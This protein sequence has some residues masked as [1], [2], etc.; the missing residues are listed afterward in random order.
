MAEQDEIALDASLRLGATQTPQVVGP[1]LEAE[2]TLGIPRDVAERNPQQVQAIQQRRAQVPSRQIL[3]E[4]PL[5]AEFMMDPSNAALAQKDVP[6]LMD[7]ERRIQSSDINT[8]ANT[9]RLVGNRTNTLTGNLLQAVASVTDVFKHV[10][11]AI[12]YPY[13]EGKEAGMASGEELNRMGALSRGLRQTGVAVAEG[14]AY[15]YIPEFTFDRMLAEPTPSNIAGLLFEQGVGS[16]PDMLAA[17]YALPAYVTSLSQEIAAER[18]A[19]NGGAP[20]DISDIV[21]VL[22]LSVAIAYMDRFSTKGMLGALEESVDPAT[23]RQVATEMA[24]ASGREAGTEFIQESAQ[25][26]GELA[27]TDAS[28]GQGVT[29]TDSTQ[30][31]ELA[32]LF[33]A[34]ARRGAE[35]AFIGAG[36]G[37][38]VRGVT[39]SVQ[40]VAQRRSRDLTTEL[41]SRF[42]QAD[43]DA[44][45]MQLQDNTFRQTSTPR[46]E[47]FVNEISQGQALYLAPEVLE[48]AQAAGIDVPF[49]AG[50]ATESADLQISYADIASVVDNKDVMAVLRPY[51]KRSP[52]QLSQTELKEQQDTTETLVA[53]ATQ[54]QTVRSEADAIYDSVRE[55]IVATGRQGEATARYSAELIPAYVTTKVAELRARGIETSVQDVYDSLGLRIEK[56]VEATPDALKQEIRP[57]RENL[58]DVLDSNFTMGTVVG[59]QMLPIEGLTTSMSAAADD[60][61]RVKTLAEQIGSTEGFIERVIVDTDG[62]VI[63]GQHRVEALRQLGITSVPATVVRDL[64]SVVSAVKGA[65]VRSEHARQIVDHVVEIRRKGE[66]VAEY[67]ISPELAE[68]Y[69]VAE[70]MLPAAPAASTTLRQEAKSAVVQGE[71]L[72][73]DNEAIIRL[74]NASDLSTFL[75]EAG[76]LFLEAERRFAVKY[77][78]SPQ[79]EALLE[80]LGV[81]GFDEIG[82]PQHEMFARTFEDYLR[83]GKAPSLRLR[84]AFAAFSRWL[85]RIYQGLVRLGKELD[86]D[87]VAVFDRLLAT[88]VEMDEAAAS[89][90]YQQYFRSQEQSGMTDAQW[91]KYT[92]DQAKRRDRSQMNL[93]DKLLEQ[94]RRT[95]TEEW[96]EERRHLYDEEMA[97][98]AE[99]PITGVMTALKDVKL[100]AAAVKAILGVEHIPPGRLLSNSRTSDGIDPAVLA[101]GYGYDSVAQMLDEIQNYTRITKDAAAAAADARMLEKYGDILNDGTIE[102]EAREAFHNDAQA[103]VLLAEIAAL[104]KQSRA[105]RKPPA[106]NREELKARAEQSVSTMQAS[107][108]NPDR[109]YRAEVRAAKKAGATKDPAEALQLKVQQL[110]NHYLYRAA[111]TAQR[112]YLKARAHIM[113]VRTRKYSTAEVS[114][115]YIQ[116]MKMLAKMY[117]TNKAPLRQA[118]MTKLVEWYEGQLPASP[119]LTL[120]DLSLVR[121]LAE[122]QA[123]RAAGQPVAATFTPP[124][125]SDLTVAEVESVYEQ[126][127]HLRYIGGRLSH[128]GQEST[129]AQREALATAITEAASGRKKRK[130]APG[131]HD[132]LAADTKHLLNSLLTFRNLI[133]ELD[134]YEIV[135]NDLDVEGAAFKALYA[136]VFDAESH[137]IALK[138]EMADLFKK[139]MGEISD[140]TMRQSGVLGHTDLTFQKENGGTWTLDEAGRVMLAAYWG[141]A[142]NRQAIRDGHGVTDGDVEAM[143]RGLTDAQVALVNAIWKLNEH[144]YPRIAQT[145]REVYG[146]APSRT[147]A[148]QF[149]IGGRELTGGHMTLFYA[150]VPEDNDFIDG[151]TFSNSAVA[152]LRATAAHERVGSGGR[153]VDLDKNSI[154]RAMD[155][156]I[157]YIAFA[158]VGQDLQRLLGT[159]PGASQVRTA[160]L[161]AH[162][163]GFLKALTESIQGITTTRKHREVYPALATLARTLRRARTVGFLA[164]SPRNT[165]QQ[166]TT[167]PILTDELGAINYF[168][169]LGAM[170]GSGNATAMIDFIHSRSAI[171]ASRAVLVNRESAEI[172]QEMTIEGGAV[173]RT[174]AWYKKHG[175]TPQA[176]ADMLLAYPAWMARYEAEMGAHNDA[177]RA[178]RNADIFVGETVG[179]GADIFLSNA[180]RSNQGENV[181]FLTMMGSWSNIYMNRVVAKSKGGRK[182]VSADTLTAAFAVPLMISVVAQTLV[183]DGPNEDESVAWWLASSYADFMFGLAFLLRD[184]WRAGKGFD[185]QAQYEAAVGLIPEAGRAFNE[186]QEGEVGAA[187]MAS[188]SIKLVSSVVPVGG[189]GTITRVLDW[190]ESYEQGNEA[191][192]MDGPVGVAAEVWQATVEGP[193]RND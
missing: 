80:M 36:V 19:N 42:A 45:L 54:D 103:E 28:R 69:R 110:A 33:G 4:S 111:V 1:A 116:Q 184:I 96:K 47:E 74:G 35:G 148:L 86:A 48:A 73:T 119:D 182:A 3:T 153:L 157:H 13:G 62:N 163:A 144:L 168:K 64:S 71:T 66:E 87:T 187:G 26:L 95:R 2:A 16:V 108:L 65:G 129:R 174:L 126:L 41:T 138:K 151:K 32:D 76:H 85:T 128:N 55:Q 146:V 159:A 53:A 44:Q 156:N 75:H 106:I 164:F 133:R 171:M 118:Q 17:M 192:P 59:D 109:F 132:K 137:R 49:L 6:T 160:I 166:L 161:D 60:A 34:A 107:T 149:S 39:A 22:P 84:D 12:R 170:Y 58:Q 25:A 127:R 78:V 24:K 15:D 50:R 121:A 70:E 180:Y 147:T 191:P 82:V 27:G 185:Q 169:H 124:R 102:A 61:A 152:P 7:L 14:E 123:Q 173:G 98:A 79:Q 88:Q 113:R 112:D 29:G 10:E 18:A 93:Q 162:G 179:S 20:V 154:F 140:L 68:A 139:E 63:E 120:M 40:A 89:P 92:E 56:M 43:L 155:E 5:L 8:F 100:D 83:T 51:L 130:D 188:T 57:A 31:W 104:R 99:M 115:I 181:R 175:F 67:E 186:L 30:L 11:D 21:S 150:D 37:G 97:R 167:I 143:L 145:S 52:S 134:G 90:E 177:T 81:K 72:I 193:D 190:A 172:L 46:F 91:K 165:V 122:R 101:E 136:P 176:V 189:A 114:P 38:G 105:P 142:G 94:F 125:F 141:E 117:N 135:G 23:L 178:A 9:M 183:V 131:K 158:K 77:G